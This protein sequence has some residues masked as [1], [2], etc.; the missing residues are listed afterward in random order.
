MGRCTDVNWDQSDV[1]LTSAAGIHHIYSAPFITFRT[2]QAAP[3]PTLQQ[4]TFIIITLS[5][6]SG[7]LVYRGMV[8]RPTRP[9]YFR[10]MA[11]GHQH[12]CLLPNLCAILC[13]LFAAET[14]VSISSNTQAEQRS[15]QTI[16]WRR[17]LSQSFEGHMNNNNSA[18]VD[19]W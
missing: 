6:S 12:L 5:I 14:P 2:Q 8:V 16:H 19:S 18:I 4:A 3:P 17:S 15:L 1:T 9:S 7:A 13:R 11:G 10:I